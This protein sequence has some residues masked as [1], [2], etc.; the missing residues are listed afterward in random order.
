MAIL[1][2]HEI[3]EQLRFIGK[4]ANRPFISWS[5]EMDDVDP[6]YFFAL[7]QACSFRERFYWSDR[8]N[9]TVYVGLGCTYS[10]ET[11]EKEQRFQ[12]VETKWKKWMEQLAFDHH[13]TATTPILFG[14][15]S[16]DPFKP[17]TEKWRAFPHAKMVVPTV[18]L[19][20]KN[21]KATLTVTVPSMRYEESMEK[22]GMLLRLL[23]QEQKQP[24]ASLPTLVKYEEA[25]KDEWIHAVEK[26]IRNIREGKFD[27]VVLAREARLSFAD[28]IDPVVVLQQL[29]EQQ[30]FSYLFAFEQDGQCFIGASPEQLVKK[31]GD[32]CYSICLAG[33]IRRGKTLQEDEQLGQW[34]MRDEK[35]LREHQFVV[36]MMKEAMGS[37]CKRVQIPAS[38]Q[39]LK[40]QHIQHL[41]TP[42]IGE[43]CHAASVLS[44]VEQM[45]P[46]PA[47]GGTPREK[48]I[49][50]IR[51]TEPLDRGWYAAPIGWMDA[52]GNGEF[53]VAIRSGLF[54]GK[55]AFI[56]AGCGVVGD[57]DPM[58]E[59]EETKVKLTPMLSALGVERDE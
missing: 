40:L 48:A 24:T 6:V 41:Y 17:R 43:K 31:E 37:V 7:G 20:L 28:V 16:F 11:E 36:Q 5:G 42:V 2:Q 22:I 44:I 9:E 14:G 1:Y 12:I 32:A 47:L 10:I 13:G 19:S 15:F 46:T 51:E 27:K 56:F 38:P 39:L 52:E 33:S 23:S 49:K 57:S 18:L 29:R 59:Y 34:L 30:P 4:K 35:N 58:S 21:G 50:E 26:T 8:A 45:H 53:A 54:Q 25:Q 55:E 3:E